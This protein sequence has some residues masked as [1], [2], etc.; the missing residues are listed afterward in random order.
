MEVV[1]KRKE[2]ALLH[3]RDSSPPMREPKYF[4][5]VV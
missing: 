4:L 5:V 3:Y 1:G 2:V